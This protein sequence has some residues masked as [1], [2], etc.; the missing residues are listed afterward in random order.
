MV[1]VGGQPLVVHSMRAALVCRDVT[2]VV[3]VAPAGHGEQMR[4][5]VHEDGLP[6]AVSVSVVEGGAERV[7]SVAI[8]VARLSAY[9]GIVLV[10][11]AARALAP[12]EV[13]DAV[14]G[15]VR[16]GHSAVV[17]VVPVTDTIKQVGPARRREPVEPDRP[18]AGVGEVVLRTIERADL[19]IAQTPQ[20][21]LRETLLHAHAAARAE[22][23]STDDAAMVEALGG[24]V[25]TVAGD[26]RS[27]KITTAHDLA[28]AEM[29]LAG[30]P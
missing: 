1:S 19:R 17:P 25:F 26:H 11:D 8:G 5:V 30:A 24:T 9:V 13:F 22:A 14:V 4:E 23:A 16:A 12:V 10:H 28:V 2:E 7:D 21:F 3:V 29:L 27:L 15:A 6:D 18:T 20:G